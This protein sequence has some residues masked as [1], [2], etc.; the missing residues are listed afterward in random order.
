MSDTPNKGA[1]LYSNESVGYGCHL[2]VHRYEV[3]GK[4][5]G[6]FHPITDH[7]GTEVVKVKVKVA[8]VH[9]T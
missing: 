7:K 8:R 2:T 3:K 5:K 9:C 6:K 1:H 4:G